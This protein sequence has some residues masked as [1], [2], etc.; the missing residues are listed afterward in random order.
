MNSVT[1]LITSLLVL[2]LAYRFYG[3]FLDGVVGTDDTRITPAHSC[4]DGVDYVAAPAP[5][6]LGHHFASI[7]GAAPII[8]PIAAAQYGWGPVVLWLLIGGIFIGAVHDFLALHVSIRHQGRSIGEVI[9]QTLGIPGKRL[10]LLFSFS[11]LILVVAVFTILVARTFADVPAAATASLCFIVSAVG[12]G[13]LTQKGGWSLWPA[14]GLGILLLTLSLVAGVWFPL[15]LTQANWVYLLLG[16]IF[17]ASVL[18][19]WLLLQPRD[20]L[21][22]F[23]LYAM[24]VSGV[25]SV[26]YNAPV[27]HLPLFTSFVPDLKGITS[28]GAMFPLLFVTVACGAVSGFHSLVASGTTAKQLDRESHARP[29]AYGGMLIETALAVLALITAATLSGADYVALAR[30]PVAL[31]S[32]QLGGFLAVLGIP[33]ELAVSFIALTVSA[34]ALTSLDTATRLARYAFQEF[35]VDFAHPSARPLAENRFLATLAPVLLGGSLALSGQWGVIWPVFGAAN[36]LL[37][38]LA[39]LAVFV[40]FRKQGLAVKPLVLPMIFMLAVTLS[41]LWLLLVD[42]W[43]KSKYSMTMAA[44]LLLLLS[45]ALLQ[46]AARQILTS[47]ESRN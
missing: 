11:A 36:Q 33:L 9:G 4:A 30:N 24:M 34:F 16:Y 39:L 27:L 14:T 40:W 2:S 38:G 45:L 8:G 15:S 12:F 7:A 42:N 21:N 20:Y 13:L 28:L 44:L 41:A 5:V 26:L 35:F 18:P 1:I 31:F 46:L 17:A 32:R 6:L 25:F 19:V 10:F 23:L 43:Q 29:V 22:S 3:R 47:S 37:A